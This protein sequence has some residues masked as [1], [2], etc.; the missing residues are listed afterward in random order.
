MWVILSTP[1]WGTSTI[2]FRSM[3]AVMWN[4]RK[5]ALLA[6]FPIAI[7]V[8]FSTDSLRPAALAPTRGYQAKWEHVERQYRDSH[9]YW[10]DVSELKRQ[11]LAARPK[12]L[13]AE[14]SRCKSKNQSWCLGSFTC[15]CDRRFEPPYLPEPKFNDYVAGF[16]GFGAALLPLL[17][18]LL[19]AGLVSVFLI[20]WLPRLSR[21]ALAWLRT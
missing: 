12:C 17:R 4:P 21:S 13:A 10:R 11:C 6:F 1:N 19:I 7:L 16:V 5:L 8:V 20:F 14:Q 2:S 15:N 9:A 18:D 3:F